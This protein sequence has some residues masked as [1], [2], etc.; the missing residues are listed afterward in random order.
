[1]LNSQFTLKKS[2]NSNNKK[3]KNESKTIERIKEITTEKARQI[4]KSF[5]PSS[6]LE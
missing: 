2:G 4:K 5:I 6:F 1:M 3:K